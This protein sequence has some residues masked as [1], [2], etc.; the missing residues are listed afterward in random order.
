MGNRSS[1]S[2][3]GNGVVTY[4]YDNRGQLIRAAG[5]TIY[6][7]TYDGAGN[8]LTATIG[9][10]L[11]YYNGTRWYFT[12]ENGRRLETASDGI[13][14]YRYEYNAD[15]MRTQKSIPEGGKMVECGYICVYRTGNYRM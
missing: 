1:Y 10:P 4:T 12:W 3:S 13:D 15:G 14:T 5:D 11:R 2:E 7:Y 6:N 8:I 9:N